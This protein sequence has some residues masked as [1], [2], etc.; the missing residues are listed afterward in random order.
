MWRRRIC[1]LGASLALVACGASA[2]PRSEA[3]ASVPACEGSVADGECTSGKPLCAY[4]GSDACLMCRCVTYA[5]LT[6]QRPPLV[7]R[8]PSFADP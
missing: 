2:E 8:A 6:T 4:Q 5:P 7:Y 3:V 1:L